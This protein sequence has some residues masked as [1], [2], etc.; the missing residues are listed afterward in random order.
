MSGAGAGV[1]GRDEVCE[2]S[3][4]AF[5]LAVQTLGVNAENNEIARDLLGWL[6]DQCNGVDTMLKVAICKIGSAAV[7][8]RAV[9]MGADVTTDYLYAG[10]HPRPQIQH[11]FGNEYVTATSSSVLRTA[12]LVMRSTRT[13]PVSSVRAAAAAAAA[14]APVA[15]ARAHAVSPSPSTL[16]AVLR[17]VALLPAPAS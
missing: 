9:A 10:P 16:A 7:A 13:A 3:C 8:R 5:L 15:G 14:A 2:T 12:A 17:L 1:P 11:T 6:L 4:K